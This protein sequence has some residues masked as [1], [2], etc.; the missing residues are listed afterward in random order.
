MVSPGRNLAR[1]LVRLAGEPAGCPLIAVITDPAVIPAEAAGPPQMVPSI[2]VP[3]LTGAIA[4]GM[5]RL[6]LLV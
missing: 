1:M 4:T 5:A 3:E 6:V 2:R